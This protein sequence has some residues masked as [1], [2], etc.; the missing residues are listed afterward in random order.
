MQRASIEALIDRA[1]AALNT[2]DRATAAELADQILATDRGNTDAEDL[3]A[4]ST[5]IGEIRRLTMLVADLVDSTA[6]S[7]RIG[8][9]AYHSV[10]GGF[11]EQAQRIIA[12][13]G[14]HIG[15]T[16]GDG[17][18]AV[19]GHPVAHMDDAR[20][21]VR[22]ALDIC[23]HVAR[24]SEQARRRYGVEISVR[25]GI[26]RGLVYLDVAHDDVYGLAANLAARVSGLAPPGAVVVSTAVESLVRND[27]DLVEQPASIV[28]GV[29][30]PVAHF[31]V[32]GERSWPAT[33]VRGPLIGRDR[34]RRLIEKHWQQVQT[35]AS[36]TTGILIRGEPGIGKSRL[37]ADAADLVR[38]DTGVALEL[39]GSPDHTDVGLHPIRKL[40]ERRCGISRE[41]PPAEQLTR[42]G[43][44]FSAC[45]LDPVTMIPAVAPVLAIGPEH[46]YEP[47]AAEG[48]GLVEV[49]SA[50]VL[51]YLMARVGSDPGM[52]I[53]DDLQWF[54]EATLGLLESILCDGERRL[55]V[56]TTCRDTWTPPQWPLETIDLERLTDRQTEELIDALGLPADQTQRAQVRRRC[57]GIPFHIEQVVASMRECPPEDPHVP[58]TLYE[59]LLSQLYAERLGVPV[60]EAAAVIGREFDGALLRAVVDLSESELADALNRLITTAVLEP[61]GADTWR[62]RHELLRE[63]A[64]E[65][66]PAAARQ[67]LHSRVADALIG[68]SSGEPDWPTVA[69]H[70]EKA[71][72]EADAAAAYQQA[73]VAARRRGALAEA[74][75]H[76]GHVLARIDRCPPGPDRDRREIT[77][78]LE[79]GYLTATAEGAQSLVAVADFER[80]LQLASIGVY[81]DELV[82]ALSAVGAYYFWRADLHRARRLLDIAEARAERPWFRHALDGSRGILAWLGGDFD[83]ATKYFELA[84]RDIDENYEHQ[85]TKLWFVAHDPVALAYEHLAWTHMIRGDIVGADTQLECAVR[86]TEQ[87]AYPQRP[88]NH[89]YAIDMEIWLRAESGQFDRARPLVDM[90]LEQAHR[91]ELDE[92]YWQLLTA[93]ERAMVGGLAEVCSDS[94]DSDVLTA[95]I[96]ALTGVI[97]LWQAL[98]AATYRPFYWC[99]LA[100]FL[101][102]AGQLEAA[103]TRIDTALTFAEDTGVKFYKAELLRIR[104]R[105]HT[106]AAAQTADLV[107][108]R[109]LAREQKA[110][111]FELRS[112]L[113]D[114]DLR[115]AAARHDLTQAL[116]KM[117]SDC[118]L[119]EVQRARAILG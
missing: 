28:K 63:V 82:A 15:G 57:D 3:L 14:G 13:H 56:V 115:G 12:E 4:A 45:G 101:I 100:R 76:L 62:F 78:R 18:F 93:T 60:A 72:R 118:P 19:F 42:L 39:A 102:A 80:C 51:S 94:P 22:V 67:A 74:R 98:G 87:L 8:P 35:D 112:S 83:T 50:S 58:D 44:E 73:S 41:T 68:Q 91:Y 47:V 32:L 33:Q 17:I 36:S 89:L 81:D 113:D 20:R 37:A 117:P 38:N 23:G 6:L 111:L 86:R 40:L 30:D 77:A 48:R 10:V 26:H 29:V 66:V 59:P 27:F 46:G 110:W 25:I 119:P 2:G 55:L 85:L 11:R 49:I 106:D 104:A 1:V 90:L 24:I 16:A 5:N 108:A 96:G 116:E 53:A 97:E 54:D 64:M 114:F 95:Q 70:Y 109:D 107:A 84:T 21:A 34:E 61:M 71:G 65:L 43:I 99:M 88:Y 7:T 103:R 69:A 75:A 9:D 79:R 92:V 105:T 52:L 31:R